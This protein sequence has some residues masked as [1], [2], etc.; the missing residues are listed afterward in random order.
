MVKYINVY[1]WICALKQFNFVSLHLNLMSF[2]VT[3]P[4]DV[5]VTATYYSRLHAKQKHLGCKKSARPIRS[6]VANRHVRLKTLISAGAKK[7][8]YQFSTP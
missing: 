4:L 3:Y 6:N 8:L 5:Y 7:L 1:A 2:T